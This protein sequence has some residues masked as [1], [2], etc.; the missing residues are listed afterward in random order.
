MRYYISDL[1]FFHE[2]LNTNL[3][4]RGFASIEEMHRYMIKQ[5]NGRVRDNDDVVI[6]GDFSIGHS[7]DTMEI[8][9]QLKG[10]KY[11]ITGNHDKYIEESHFDKTVF[12]WI[13]PYKELRDNKR[14]VILS[15]YPV[16]CY[17]GQN[18]MDGQGEPKAYMLYGHVHNSLD[19][20]LMNRFI[21]QTRQT[22]RQGKDG[23][24]HIPCA[25]INCFCMFSDYVPL[26]LDEWIENDRNRRAVLN[27]ELSLE[28]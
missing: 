17:N 4:H 23:E 26:T 5:W 21:M 7:K 11:L 22:T 10:R 24:Y 27:Q 9:S 14:K 28:A 20:V 3:D 25:M 13:A 12:E 15:H 6:L 18:N 19:E 8:L 16:M 1:H 2:R